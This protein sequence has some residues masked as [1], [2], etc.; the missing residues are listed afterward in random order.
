[1]AAQKNRSRSLPVSTA[2][3]RNQ[4]ATSR[5]RISCMSMVLLREET[6][7]A[8]VSAKTSDAVSPAGR[9]K[10]FA[11]RMYI[12]TLE[13]APASACGSSMAQPW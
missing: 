6:T 7:T 1:M 10:R 2:R 9:P 3:N 13:A 4:A 11:V 8:G 5:T 12:I